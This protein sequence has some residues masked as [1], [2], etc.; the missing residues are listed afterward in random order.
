[1]L[2]LGNRNL[3]ILQIRYRAIDAADAADGSGARVKAGTATGFR[4]GGAGFGRAD[5]R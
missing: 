4:S 5:G 3:I 1:M 2:F